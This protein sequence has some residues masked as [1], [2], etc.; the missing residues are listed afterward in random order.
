MLFFFFY[1]VCVFLV[2]TRCFHVSWCVCRAPAGLGAALRWAPGAGAAGGAGAGG[3][4]GR[5][6]LPPAVAS[7]PVGSIGK[8]LSHPLGGRCCK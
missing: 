4:A 7:S 2:K 1:Y 3:G 6:G 8:A 5:F